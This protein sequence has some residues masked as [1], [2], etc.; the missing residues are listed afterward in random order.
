MD[1]ELVL[2]CQIQQHK[3]PVTLQTV[4]TVNGSDGSEAPMKTEPAPE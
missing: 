2:F 1:C 4:P 3:V